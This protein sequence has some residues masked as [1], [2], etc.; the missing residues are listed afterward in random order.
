MS[1]ETYNGGDKCQFCTIEDLCDMVPS[2]A[3]KFKR[4]WIV[5]KGRY[6]HS[7]GERV[8]DTTNLGT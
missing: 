8:P 5:N 4:Y 6:T 7:A 1:G 3:K 2:L